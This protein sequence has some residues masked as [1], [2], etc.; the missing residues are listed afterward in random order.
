MIHETT[1]FLNIDVKCTPYRSLNTSMG[2][3]R[4]H[5]RDLYDMSEA[6]IVMEIREQGVEEVPRFILKKDG[7]EVKTNTLSVTFLTP[8]P[9]E[10]IPE[11]RKRCI[12]RPS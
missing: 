2:V 12:I 1:N 4:D 9:P 10:N 11:H 3:I 8:T 5:G 7:K 6:D